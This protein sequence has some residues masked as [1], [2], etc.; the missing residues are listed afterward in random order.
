MVTIGA[1]P[2]KRSRAWHRAHWGEHVSA[3]GRSGLSA[4]DYCREHGLH[5]KSFYRWKRRLRASGELDGVSG[6]MHPARGNG[7]GG[8]QF[9][10]VVVDGLSGS[11]AALEVV[12]R[13]GRRVQVHPG[14]DD[15]TLARI[16]AV[17]ERASC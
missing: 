10:E 9:A 6:E 16:V 4:V 14:F 12:V 13:H 5:L 8:S 7:H 17:L 11:G 15:E 3:Q 2:C 1:T